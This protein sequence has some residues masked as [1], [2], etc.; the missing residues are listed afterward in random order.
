VRAILHLDM[1]AFYASVEQRDDPALRG[2]PVIVGGHPMR[3]VVLAASYEIRP[4]GVHSAMPMAVALRLAPKALVVPP[5]FEAYVEASSRVFSI[6]EDVTPLCE[7]LSLD[8]AFLDVTD[9]LSLFGSPSTIARNLRAR[10]RDEVDLPCSAGIAATK[11]VAKIASDLAKPNG[12]REVLEKDTRAFL[13]PLPVGRLFGVGPKTAEVLHHAGIMS[14]GDLAR[15][16]QAWLGEHLGDG[17]EALYRL[18]VGL[19]DRP[20]IPD[21]R[22]KSIGSEDTFEED[23]RDR[24]RLQ[25][26]LHAQAWRVGRRL[27]KAGLRASVVTL[28]LKFADFR[29]RHR[30]MTLPDPTDDGQALYRAVLTLLEREPL[31]MALRLTGVSAGGFDQAQ[32]PLFA[33]KRLSK[34]NAVLDQIAEKH[35]AAAVVPADLAETVEADDG[36]ARTRAGGSRLSDGLWH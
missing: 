16:G 13:E 6:F 25:L 1:D 10:I 15:R 22:A 21:R 27:R 34:L 9:S 11:F 5:R 35:G 18:S 8:E 29:I 28:K 14:I 24:S 12:Q 33:S 36:E 19:D 17:G 23:T 26:S 20:V 32:V 30:Q 7:P 4:F 2:K 31:D 3:G